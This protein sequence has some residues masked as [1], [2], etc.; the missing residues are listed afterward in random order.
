MTTILPRTPTGAPPTTPRLTG[1]GLHVPPPP[2]HHDLLPDL[3]DPAALEQLG[4]AGA[5]AGIA[6]EAATQKRQALLAQLLLRRQLRRVALR[7]VVHDGPLVVERGPGSA[8]RA[9]F[10]DDAAER[11]DVDGALAAFVLPFDHFGRH[12]HGGAG[13]GFLFRGG[14][15]GRAGGAEAVVFVGGGGGGCGGWVCLEG[16]ALAG[17]DFGGAEVDVLDYAVVVEEDV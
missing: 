3:A 16:F 2:T 12:V 15:A 14:H 11:P 10:Q 13:H 5:T 6:L 17:D 9:H 4:G 1:R 8:A 7:D